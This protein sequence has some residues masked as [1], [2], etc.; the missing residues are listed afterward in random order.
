M[1]AK[2]VRKLT[3]I[4]LKTQHRVHCPE[5]GDLPD[6]PFDT[7]ADARAARDEH[8]LTVHHADSRADWRSS[9]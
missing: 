4:E 7:Q 8:W 5:C 6:S 2:R 9:G 3:D 1:T